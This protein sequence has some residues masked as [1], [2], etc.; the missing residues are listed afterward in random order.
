MSGSV[1]HYH[2]ALQFIANNWERFSWNDL[3]SNEY[4]LER[5]NE[6]VEGMQAWREIKPAIVFGD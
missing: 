3:I 5:I 1:E 6:A 2:R 4:P